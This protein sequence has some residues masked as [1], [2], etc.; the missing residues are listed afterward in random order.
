MAAR[1]GE[2]E[3]GARDARVGWK[4]NG[5][6]WA[7]AACG[8]GTAHGGKSTSK[9]TRYRPQNRGKFVDEQVGSAKLGISD[10]EVFYYVS[11]AVGQRVKSI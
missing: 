4:E 3:F 8:C 2:R 7:G 11:H 5:R 6:R 9:S 1:D 10:A